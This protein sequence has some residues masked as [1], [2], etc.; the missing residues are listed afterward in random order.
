MRHSLRVLT[1][2][3]LL[4]WPSNGAA[5]LVPGGGDLPVI[6]RSNLQVN[7]QTASNTAAIKRDTAKLVEFAIQ[8]LQRVYGSYYDMR[9]YLAELQ[10]TLLALPP[11]QVITYLHDVDVYMQARFPG[12]FPLPEPWPAFYLASSDTGLNTL[13][14]TLNTVRAELSPSDDIRLQGVIDELKGKTE[15]AKG[16]LDVTQTGNYIGI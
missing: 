12:Y 2:T 10:E 1:L 8:N 7:A 11:E 9:R 14:L 15:Y 5:Q 16:N 13:R 4:V 3:M 6:D